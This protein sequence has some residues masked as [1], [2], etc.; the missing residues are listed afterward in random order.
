M[1]A[2]TGKS[3]RAFGLQDGTGGLRR[4][5]LLPVARWLATSPLFAA[6]GRALVSVSDRQLGTNVRQD[7]GSLMRWILSLKN[8]LTA[9]S[10]GHVYIRAANGGICSSNVRLAAPT[11]T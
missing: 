10:A 9:S 5:F 11:Q 3:P 7:D 8:I 6:N 4:P 1:L 2:N